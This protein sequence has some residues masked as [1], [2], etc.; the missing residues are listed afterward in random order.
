MDPR[1]LE[2]FDA[3]LRRELLAGTPPPDPA[4]AR[5]AL[6]RDLL[7]LQRAAHPAWDRLLAATGVPADAPW[8]A[9]AAPSLLF[10]HQLLFA[11]APSEI[12]RIFRS[13]GTTDPQRRSQAAFSARGLSLMARAIEIGARAALF[14]DGG[15]GRILVLAPP[16]E[17][18]PD[19]IMAWGMARLIDTFG[20]PGSRFLMGHKG[21]DLADLMTALDEACRDGRPVTLIGA[22]FGFVHLLDAFVAQGKSFNLPPGSR[23]LDAGGFKGRSRSMPQAALHHLIQE[24]LGIPATHT[25]NLLGMTELASQLYDDTLAAHH[26]G[27][28]PRGLKRGPPWTDTVAVHPD[29]LE[30]VPDGEIG[31]LVHLDLANLERPAV[32]RSSDLGRCLPGGFEVLGRAEAGEAAGCSLRIEELLA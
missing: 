26:E 25:V 13:S 6:A 28:P 21:L 12:D 15:G 1:W 16:P 3:R 31:L 17:L 9:Q 23:T 14:P 22:S 30:P 29:S 10:R 7:P 5:E 20:A 19:M 32:V 18:A 4:D 11:G 2:T 27:R 8:W 24:R